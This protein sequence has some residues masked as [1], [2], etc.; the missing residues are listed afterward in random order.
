MTD[1]QSR[2]LQELA[3]KAP[4]SVWGY[5]PFALPSL[6]VVAG[7]IVHLVLMATLGRGETL[8]LWIKLGDDLAP[9]WDSQLVRRFVLSTSVLVLSSFGLLAMLARTAH[10]QRLLLV[11]LAEERGIGP[12]SPERPRTDR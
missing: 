11:A 4:G 12:P 2:Q 7:A 9:A 5:W 3:F 8:E 6:I 1:L 10:R